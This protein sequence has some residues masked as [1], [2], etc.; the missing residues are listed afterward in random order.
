MKVNQRYRHINSGEIWVCLLPDSELGY[1]AGKPLNKVGEAG[2]CY[3]M[4]PD[5]F[6]EVSG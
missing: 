1:P 3:V 2:F 4:F 6:V 5:L